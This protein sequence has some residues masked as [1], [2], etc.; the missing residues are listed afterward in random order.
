MCLAETTD[1]VHHHHEHEHEHQQRHRHDHEPHERLGRRRFLTR[2]GALAA[3][4]ALAA[5]APSV[6]V[7][8]GG[9]SRH[10]RHRK[11][12]L[13]LTHR[14][15]KDFPTFTGDQPT[16][17]IVADYATDGFY[18]KRW[19]I[20]EH[21]GT[22]IDTPG[23]FNEGMRLVDQL[24]A[25]ELVAPVAVIDITRKARENPNA[26][27]EPDDLI[28]Y[29]KR[30]GRIPDRALVC[31][32][33]GWA[34]KAGDPAAFLGGPAFP[35]F[36][37]PGFSIEATDWLLQRRNPVGIGVDTVSLDPGNSTTFDVHA[38]FLRADRYGV[39]NLNNL[40]R[41]PPRGADVFVGPIPWE[42]GSGSPCH[43]IVTW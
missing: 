4:A 40:D 24:D 20:N 23:H 16:D 7:A 22:H 28:R 9:G 39:E 27:V 17:E 29:E 33:S 11:R 5:T 41:V 43:V 6:A 21:T 13:D 34:A 36:N 19:T 30:H 31:M 15:R 12:V 26:T 8:S 38:G 14:L 42:D 2:G 10:P 35:D 32:N 18:A 1:A 3:G 37:F 25:A